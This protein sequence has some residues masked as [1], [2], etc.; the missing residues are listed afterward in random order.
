M[1]RTLEPP[2]RSARLIPSQGRKSAMAVIRRRS[3]RR[4]S[5]ACVSCDTTTRSREVGALVADALEYAHRRGVLHRD[6]KPSN[7]LL[8]AMGNVWVTDF[9]LARLEKAADPSHSRELLNWDASLHG[10]R[11]I[12]GNV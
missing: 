10:T 12:S 4:R 3:D 6:V 11:A 1:A 9:G 8:D 2:V 7:L 5:P